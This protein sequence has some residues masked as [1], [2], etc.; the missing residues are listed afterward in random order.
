MKYCIR[1]RE[2]RNLKKKYENKNKL[3]KSREWKG[4]VLFH[5]HSGTWSDFS[6]MLTTRSC[7]KNDC[8]QH[9]AIN[10]PQTAWFSVLTHNYGCYRAK[11]VSRFLERS[12]ENHREIIKREVLGFGMVYISPFISNRCAGRFFWRED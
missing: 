7:S 12:L 8:Q 5:D 4:I 9:S 10:L 6:R 11:G 2:K 3:L 1:R